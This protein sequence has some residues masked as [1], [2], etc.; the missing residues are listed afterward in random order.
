MKNIK[1]TSQEK[2]IEDALLNNEY[3]DLSKSDFEDIAK[4]ISARKR[5]AVLNIRVNKKDIEAIKTIARK[6]GI[7]YQTFI[8]ELIHRAANNR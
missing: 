5:N 8:S 6:F 2:E 4:S 1:L 3:L 7:G